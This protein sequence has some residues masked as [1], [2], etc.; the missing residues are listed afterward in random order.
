MKLLKISL[1]I[2]LV[3]L[4]IGSV[5]AEDGNDTVG[6]DT[7]INEIPVKTYSELN[8]QVNITEDQ[9]VINLTDSYKFNQEYDENLTDGIKISKNLTLVGKNNVSIDGSYVAR[10][11][12]I[13]ANCNVVLENITFKNAYSLSS[14]GAIYV[15]QNST[16]TINNC[17]FE[18]NKVYN[19]NGGAIYGQSG[20]NIVIHNS[21][22][23]NNTGKRVSKL[24]WKEYKKGMGSAICMMIGTSLKL[25]DTI[26]RDNIGYLT[27]ILI[28][29][30]DDVNTNQST[31]YV[32]NCLF[33]NNTARSNGVIYLDEFGIAEIVDSIFRDNTVT[34]YGGTV[35]FDT[36]NSALVKNCTFEGNS[37]VN[38]GAIYINSYSPECRS[39]VKI[40][41]SSFN[42][43][44]VDGYGGVIYSKYGVTDIANSLFDNNVALKNG[45]AIYSKIGSINI[46]DCRFT[47]NVADYGGALLLK[48]DVNKVVDSDFVKNEALVSG[49]AIYSSMDNVYSSGCSYSKNSAPKANNVYGIFY[50]Q[51]TKYTALSGYVKLKI[52][53]SSPWKMSLSQ[54]IKIKLKGYTSKWL[55]TDSKGQLTFTV[56]KKI[57]VGKSTISFTMDN[58][59]CKINEYIYKD[60]GQIT[61][62]KI[63]KKPSKLKVTIKN[64]Y[65]KNLIKKTNFVV[66]VYTGKNFKKYNLKTNSK[67]IFNIDVKKLSKGNHKIIFYLK[68]QK[69]YI[70]KKVNVKIK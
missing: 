70:N 64:K 53:I 24:P 43:N 49:G 15:G 2:C 8:N 20:T 69:Y 68:N 13:G 39:N 40:I 28:V 30:W 47:S 37:A 45:G 66:K 23:C 65:T 32:K 27:T 34:Y 17:I 44:K 26:F 12:L 46:S 25:Y 1:L 29:T 63:G 9:S 54:K 16:L 57:S 50:A 7:E 14:G 5:H 18:S 51:V 56:P 33:E 6:N 19:S 10:G 38:G 59:F 36:A 4:L 21:E 58:G 61:I 31:L 3:L 11:L 22:F 62:K 52:V 42:N 41:D 60:P 67:G 35:V 48:S 55:K